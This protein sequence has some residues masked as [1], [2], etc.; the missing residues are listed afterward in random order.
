MEI[1][2]KKIIIFLLVCSSLMMASDNGTK[3]SKISKEALK[4][5]MEQEKKFAEEQR[6]YT[7]DDYDFKGAEVD[8]KSLDGI[9]ALEPDYDF[10]MDVGVYD[11]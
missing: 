8:P 4:K 3:K 6:F 2:M 10:D 11:D 7:M 9:K 1:I 5:A